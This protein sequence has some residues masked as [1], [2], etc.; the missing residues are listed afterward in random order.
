MTSGSTG[1][2]SIH[3]CQ[4]QNGKANQSESDQD[5]LITILMFLCGNHRRWSWPYNDLHNEG[6]FL[7]AL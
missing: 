3:K 7:P 1:T 4:R 2:L 5:P 6:P